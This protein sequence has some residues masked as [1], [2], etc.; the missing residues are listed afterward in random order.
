[1]SRVRITRNTNIY[2]CHGWYEY[3]I[4]KLLINIDELETIFPKRKF[5]SGNDI[6]EHIVHIDPGMC[7]LLSDSLKNLKAVLHELERKRSPESTIS[8]VNSKSID[9]ITD[10]IHDVKYLD[11]LVQ[12]IKENLYYTYFLDIM[13]DVIHVTPTPPSVVVDT[14]ETCNITDI[15]GMRRLISNMT[16]YLVSLEDY[17]VN[18]ASLLKNTNTN[19]EKILKSKK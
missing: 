9:I 7:I 5:L 16:Y 15:E 19:L 6:I 4:R 11:L 1:M 2:T 17:Q 12:N 8:A 13:P 14:N 10:N 18:I 3:G